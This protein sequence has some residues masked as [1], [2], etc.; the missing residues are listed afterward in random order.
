M[1]AQLLLG[2]DK[3]PVGFSKILWN[4]SQTVEHWGNYILLLVGI[5]LITYGCVALFKAVKSLGG[6]QGPGGGM[7]WVKAI[8]AIILGIII[9]ATDVGNIRHNDALN[10]DTLKHA[11]NG[12]G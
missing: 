2:A 1:N 11:L 12:E 6:Q 5:V 3:A 4:I 9:A 8:L 10:K 7:E